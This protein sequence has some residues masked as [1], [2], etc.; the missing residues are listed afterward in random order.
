MKAV[1]LPLKANCSGARGSVPGAFL[2][3]F[4]QD[5]GIHIVYRLKTE[6]LNRGSSWGTSGF[7]HPVSDFC[8]FGRSLVL[9]QDSSVK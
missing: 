9:G 8:F 6:L 4:G 5:A 2:R 7:R 3:E 1:C